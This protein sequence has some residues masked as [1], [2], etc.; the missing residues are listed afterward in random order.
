MQ[1]RSLNDFFK[2]D[3]SPSERELADRIGVSVQY[4]YM[5][6][7]QERRPS[8]DI[9]LKLSEETGIS[10]DDLLFPKEPQSAA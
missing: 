2:Q 3:G 5:L 8:P 9:A 6:K 4:I 10:L 1:T 7:K